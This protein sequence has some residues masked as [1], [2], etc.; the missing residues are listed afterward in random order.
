MSVLVERLRTALDL[1]DAGVVL[2]RQTLRRRFPDKS[3]HEIDR[4]V[5][6][7]LSQRP[8]AEHGDG[9]QPSTGD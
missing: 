5:N 9:P 7:W 2:H 1:F 4:L 8:G 3:E 6:E